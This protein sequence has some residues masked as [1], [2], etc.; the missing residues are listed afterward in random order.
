MCDRV[1]VHRYEQII[2]CFPGRV[3]WL[4]KGMVNFVIFLMQFWWVWCADRLDSYGSYIWSQF[5]TVLEMQ[6]VDLAYQ[7]FL[8][9][10]LTHMVFTLIFPHMVCS[11]SYDVWLVSYKLLW[12]SFWSLCCRI[13]HGRHFFRPQQY[14]QWYMLIFVEVGATILV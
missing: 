14:G 2:E 11:H 6:F 4:T 8:H 3:R 10:T 12:F 9:F 13:Y 5:D 1:S 7:C